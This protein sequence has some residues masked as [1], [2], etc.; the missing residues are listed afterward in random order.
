MTKYQERIRGSN[1]YLTAGEEAA[2]GT[3]K[4]QLAFD[5]GSYRSRSAG[6]LLA[7]DPGGA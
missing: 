4:T 7:G 5:I 1:T 6:V 2:P 3:A